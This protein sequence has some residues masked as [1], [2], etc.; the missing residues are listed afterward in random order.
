[1][2]NVHVGERATIRFA[3]YLLSSI[4]LY[5]DYT[6]CPAHLALA[7]SHLVRP[8]AYR[9]GQ[10]TL[11]LHRIVRSTALQ[12]ADWSK[13]EIKGRG[14]SIDSRLYPLIEARLYS[15]WR[16]FKR[17]A[18]CICIRTCTLRLSRLYCRRQFTAPSVLD[19]E[20]RSESYLRLRQ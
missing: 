4:A 15:N 1:M 9:E 16:S 5:S 7:L 13:I 6:S 8:H 20:T 12:F 18:K 19:W 2:K 3:W 17:P 14:I 11:T 10:T